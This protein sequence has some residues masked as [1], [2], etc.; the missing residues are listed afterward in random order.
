[1]LLVGCLV[2]V[3]CEVFDEEVAVAG[4]IADA[5]AGGDGDRDEDGDAIG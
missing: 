3:C 4:A 1:M 2:F 5:G